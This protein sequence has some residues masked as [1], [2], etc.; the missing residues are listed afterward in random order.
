M[1]A[2]FPVALILIL[3]AALVP[4]LRG[5][6]RFIYSLL[7]PVAAFAWVLALPHGEYAQFEL[8]G[9]TLTARELFGCGLVFTAVVASQLP[10]KKLFAHKQPAAKEPIPAPGA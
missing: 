7:L 3:G 6:F 2:D 4:L 9:Q 8:L 5:R 10:W 1:S